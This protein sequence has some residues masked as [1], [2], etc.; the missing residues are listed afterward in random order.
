MRQ[1]ARGFTLVELLVVMAIMGL[2]LAI[3]LPAL[4]S[5]RGH[6]DKL[7]E[8]SDI[9]QVGMA[10]SMYA[11]AANDRLLPGFLDPEVQQKWG[12]R[13]AI[14]SENVSVP[15]AEAAPYPWRLM[16]YLGGDHF[17]LNG[18]RTDVVSGDPLEEL[19]ATARNPAFG[20]N[21]IYLGGWYESGDLNRPYRVRFERAHVVARTMA[22]I[23]RPEEIVVFAS[24]LDPGA[25]QGG[26][27]DSS[28]GSHYVVPPIVARTPQWDGSRGNVETFGQVSAPL[29]RYTS[30]VAV[31]HADGHTAAEGP[32][33]LTDQRRWIPRADRVDFTHDP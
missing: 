18:H 23:D 19:S 22:Q 8:L 21:A 3:L 32:A 27:N 26:R 29:A 10:W 20:Y 9:R 7:R 16:P 25:F 33:G 13:Y 4:G 14:A 1:N 28:P 15:A 6:G 2:L 17:L 12:A 24:S 5:A 30:Q 11:S 31:V